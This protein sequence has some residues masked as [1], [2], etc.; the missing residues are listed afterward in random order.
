[1]GGYGGGV[2]HG[3][4]NT[5]GGIGGRGEGSVVGTGHGDLG[6]LL[7]GD[8]GGVGGRDGEAGA[9]TRDSYRR[10]SCDVRGEWGCGSRC[11]SWSWS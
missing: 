7:A 6:V 9:G 11:S 5:V 10:V 2:E 8:G 4:A 1:M 3:G